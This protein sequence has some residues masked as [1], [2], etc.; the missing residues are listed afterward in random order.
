MA[1]LVP[2]WARRCPPPESPPPLSPTLLPM[3]GSFFST[4]LATVMVRF[5]K[6]R[7]HRQSSLTARVHPKLAA[8]FHGPFHIIGRIGS[9]AYRL[10][11]PLEVRIHPI[12]HVSQRKKVTGQHQAL[13]DLPSEMAI[14]E[15]LIEPA[16][17]LQRRAV[18]RDGK[19]T[20]QVLVHWQGHSQEEA[21]W[22]DFSDFCQQ[23]PNY[24]LEDKVEA[25]PG[26]IDTGPK[27]NQSGQEW[28]QEAKGLYKEEACGGS[29]SSCMRRRR[30]CVR[31]CSRILG[32]LA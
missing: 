13:T 25:L 27:M 29:S 23:F 28:A 21:T 16:A 1:S 22:V 24:S 5:L 32:Q 3:I 8:R 17:I 31:N 15:P 19:S 6:F 10:Q 4:S 20:T 30:F 2:R 12:F 7:P 11:L 14:D 9:V 26:G 18:I